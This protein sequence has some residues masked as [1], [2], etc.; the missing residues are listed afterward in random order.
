MARKINSQS[1]DQVPLPFGD[2]YTSG[3]IIGRNGEIAAAELP[4]ARRKPREKPPARP[5]PAPKEVPG[6]A[7]S[8]TTAFYEPVVVSGTVTWEDVESCAAEVLQIWNDGSELEWAEGAWNILAQAG[9]TH[10]SHAVEYH[11]VILR[12]FA[13]CSLYLDFSQIAWDKGGEIPY[14]E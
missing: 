2:N 6:A 11:Q 1:P 3:V 13:L 7:I 4:R 14:A 9:L 8:E 5:S 12:F 10:Y